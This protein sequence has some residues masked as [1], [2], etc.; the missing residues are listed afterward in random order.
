LTSGDVDDAE[1]LSLCQSIKNGEASRDDFD[2]VSSSNTI[3]TAIVKLCAQSKIF[4]GKVDLSTY[5][6]KLPGHIQRLLGALFGT[7]DVLVESDESLVLY[8]IET[9]F[10]MLFS[11]NQDSQLLQSILEDYRSLFPYCYMFFRRVGRTP[12]QKLSIWTNILHRDFPEKPAIISPKQHSSSISPKADPKEPLKD[13]EVSK[14]TTPAAKPSLA[15]DWDDEE[16]QDSDTPE[17]QVPYYSQ[18]KPKTPTRIRE[19]SSNP[20]T[21]IPT[22]SAKAS[23]KGSA[24]DSSEYGS[25][26]ESDDANID[27][28]KSANTSNDVVEFDDFSDSESPVKA[29]VSKK[30]P[31]SASSSSESGRSTP[32]VNSGNYSHQAGVFVQ[33]GVEE[34]TL[35][36]L[37]AAYN[38]NLVNSFGADK[39]SLGRDI[40]LKLSAPSLSDEVLSLAGALVPW[41]DLLIPAKKYIRR[42]APQGSTLSPKALA[43]ATA[44]RASPSN[45]PPVTTNKSSTVGITSKA[46]PRPVDAA[47]PKSPAS[48][49]TRFT[50]TS[51]ASSTS[52]RKTFR[53]SNNTSEDHG[54]SEYDSSDV[55]ADDDTVGTTN[56]RQSSLKAHQSASPRHASQA[57]L[58]SSPIVS[59]KQRPEAKEV[60]PSSLRDS[61]QQEVWHDASPAASLELPPKHKEALLAASS[62]SAVAAA[63]S[64]AEE[65]ASHASSSAAA[66][67]EMKRTFSFLTEENSL[68]YDSSNPSTARSGLPN[69]AVSSILGSSSTSSISVSKRLIHPGAVSVSGSSVGDA[70]PGSD[71]DEILHH[72]AKAVATASQH[73]LASQPSSL[74]QKTETSS[75]QKHLSGKNQSFDGSFYLSDSSMDD[76]FYG[77][78]GSNNSLKTAPIASA[79]SA[80][81]SAS[82]DDAIKNRLPSFRPIPS[83]ASDGRSSPEKQL[84]SNSASSN[85]IS[86][87]TRTTDLSM[88][89]HAQSMVALSPPYKGGVG[90]SPLRIPVEEPGSLNDQFA[91][92]MHVSPP[93]M[94][95]SPLAHHDNGSTRRLSEG[96]HQLPHPQTRGLAAPV[97]SSSPNTSMIFAR[98]IADPSSLSSSRDF[99]TMNR[100]SVHGSSSSVALAAGSEGMTEPPRPPLSHMQQSLHDGLKLQIS[101]PPLSEYAAKTGILLES[102]LEK[103][104]KRT[105]FW[106]KVSLIH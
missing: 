77:G 59:R 67:K 93:T 33:S 71:L 17:R 24:S 97:R 29:S 28:K 26:V 102:W 48:A 22:A 70:S 55:D 73:P 104:S 74:M 94:A 83:S 20:V 2:E 42:A 15:S 44:A 99:H 81:I 78:N 57:R 79:I 46:S 61:V 37:R 1:A 64:S 51:P 16:D 76:S 5:T 23:A 36:D 62:A 13:H 19:S 41:E 90:I 43:A 56:S 72:Q 66:Q 8:L 18:A 98:G 91:E 75:A 9:L 25:E 11:G 4:T 96:S 87:G 32:V 103:K 45:S 53:R 39:M 85:S 105:G 84:A 68:E 3:L 6:S 100:E 86:V 95:T 21:K 31:A 38:A 65:K 7:M 14:T 69:T 52:R 58:S 47:F 49:P 101:P 60:N 50:S 40:R 54:S 27:H 80:P 35:E 63:Q 30:P 88:N 106:N 12:K 92:Q 89:S 34:V 10:D 82:K